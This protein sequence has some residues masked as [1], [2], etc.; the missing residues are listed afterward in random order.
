MKVLG[1]LLGTRII[2][3]RSC[4]GGQCAEDHVEH[5]AVDLQG[6]QGAEVHEPLGIKRILKVRIS[7]YSDSESPKQWDPVSRSSF[8][9]NVLG[10][11]I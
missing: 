9:Y 5:H 10:R 3:A 6:N 7:M 11:C 1:Q 8:P 2:L 4:Q